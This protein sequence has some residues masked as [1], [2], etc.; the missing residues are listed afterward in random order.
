MITTTATT[1]SEIIIFFFFINK[2][3]ILKLSKIS[4][5]LF[6]L[7]LKSYIM[8]LIIVQIIFLILS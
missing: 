5:I 2:F 1:I 4:K 7:N 8:N 3:L 6:L